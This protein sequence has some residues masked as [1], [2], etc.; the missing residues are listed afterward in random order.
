MSVLCWDFDGTLVWAPKLW[1][2]S[3]YAALKAEDPSTKMKI[4]DVR[5]RMAW[6]FPGM[7]RKKTI[8]PVPASAGGS[9]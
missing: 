3:V 5:V 9:A 4:R 8:A 7:S 1:T 6:G 2:R